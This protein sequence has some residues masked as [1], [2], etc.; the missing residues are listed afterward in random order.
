MGRTLTD[1]QLDHIAAL[2]ELRTLILSGPI[3]DDGL[4]RIAGLRKLVTLTLHGTQVTDDGLM[5]LKDMRELWSLG[6]GDTQVTDSGLAHF[7]GLGSLR[8]LNLTNTA[9]SDAGLAH[10]AK[11][12]LSILRLNGTQVT[13]AGMKHLADMKDL[14]TLEVRDTRVTSDGAEQLRH[15][16]NL[17]VFRPSQPNPA[18]V[19]TAT[20]EQLARLDEVLGWLPVDTETV[21]AA[22]GPF[23]FAGPRDAYEFTTAR[24][25]ET[26]LHLFGLPKP[27]Y[28]QLLADL[29]VA[30]FVE[31]NRHFGPWT[32]AGEAFVQ[33]FEGCKIVVFEDD[34][35]ETG[36]TLAAALRQDASAVE[37]IADHDAARFDDVAPGLTTFV[38]QPRPNILL[39][40]TQREF[41]DEVLSRMAQ[42]SDDLAL[43]DD[44]PEWWQ[45]DRAARSWALRRYP[46]NPSDSNGD[47]R[48][49]LAYAVQGGDT[50]KVLYFSDG[51]Q[52]VEIARRLWPQVEVQVRQLE[53]GVVEVALHVGDPQA[54]SN[55]HFQLLSQ[56]GR[57][58]AL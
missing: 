20:A 45:I 25:L 34:L 14:I 54:T 51:P 15:L 23:A 47:L 58:I 22:R 7:E 19:E 28:E 11:L 44:L 9:V 4:R 42:P 10:L 24:A 31:G 3:T 52:T 36:A 39:I 40:A 49:G 46:R 5:H 29:R 18:T 8:D 26:V 32:A 33:P 27:E 43:P 50:A 48:I 35:G 38:V 17:S 21:I 30:L 13:D 57:G 2:G 41:L 16:E 12:P 56:L 1:A 37:R 55:F 53:D 6:L